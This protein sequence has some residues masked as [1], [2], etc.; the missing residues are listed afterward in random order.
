M[1]VR[2][3]GSDPRLLAYRS[4]APTVNLAGELAERFESMKELG[5]ALYH[6]SKWMLY[7]N[8]PDDARGDPGGEP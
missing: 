7:N 2:T 3:D 4:D 5:L 6:T 1:F 8:A